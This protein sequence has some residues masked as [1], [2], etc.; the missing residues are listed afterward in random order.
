VVVVAV[1]KGTTAAGLQ[2]L[3]PTFKDEVPQWAWG[4]VNCALYMGVITGY[5]DGTFRAGNDV[6]YGEAV[7]MLV[8]AIP[9]H[10]TEVPEGVWPY[11]YLF[12]GV[13]K[14]FTGDVDVGGAG[15]PCSRGDMAR[16]L[17]ATM[18]VPPLNADGM[19]VPGLAVLADDV[20]L[21]D[22]VL[23]YFDPLYGALFVNP[24]GHELPLADL[25]YMVGDKTGVDPLTGVPKDFPRYASLVNQPVIVVLDKPLA[26]GGK[27]IFIA[28]QD[29]TVVHGFF[30][31]TLA[32]GDDSYLRLADGTKVPY[33]AGAG[34]VNINGWFEDWS[35]APYSEASL[36]AGDEVLI[37]LDDIGMATAIHALRWDLILEHV[38]STDAYVPTEDYAFATHKSDPDPA[39][40]HGTLLWPCPDSPNYYLDPFDA[41]YYGFG[42]DLALE[43]PATA[44]VMVNGAPAGRDDLARYDV[45]KA[46]TVGAWGYWGA[47]SVIAVSATRTTVTGTITSASTQY[48]SDSPG[49]RH[50]LT[51]ATGG[52]SRTYEW[53]WYYFQELGTDTA[54]T[55]ALDEKGRLFT[56]VMPMPEIFYGYVRESSIVTSGD[57]P[58]KGYLEVDRRGK[59]QTYEYPG[60]EYLGGLE[61][62]VG[63]FVVMLLDPETGHIALVDDGGG[64]WMPAVADVCPDRPD[65]TVMASSAQTCTLREGAPGAYTYYFG[66]ET[67]SLPEWFGELLLSDLFGTVVYS[68]NDGVVTYIGSA[69]LSVDDTVWVSLDDLLGLM[70]ILRDDTPS[71]L[72]GYEFSGG[73]GTD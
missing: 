30:R 59:T 32:E 71:G 58:P 1:G 7:T 2:G 5:D 45:I 69:G 12:Y 9:G 26:E 66:S 41:N 4:Y 6:T 47:D 51:L 22:H 73:H 36:I 57:D 31:D 68:Y 63:H 11:N 21:Y 64:G 42:G 18:R 70:V 17:F 19:P 10:K 34:T 33:V 60:D 52:G 56:E 35:G 29:G 8:K 13:D 25:V 46:A 54:H 43:I 27:A 37:N 72:E 23:R 15:L 49:P 62:W 16:L 39:T 38:G 48:G 24:H 40:G 61:G 20:R 55:F 65:L 28:R 67:T 50:F 14:E 44:S 3:R 53:Q